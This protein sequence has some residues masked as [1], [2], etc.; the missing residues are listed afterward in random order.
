MSQPIERKHGCTGRTLAN[1]AP[2]APSSMRVIRSACTWTGACRNRA[3]PGPTT[4]YWRCS[5]I[6]TGTEC[7]P[8]SCATQI[9]PAN[10]TTH[11]DPWLP[12]Q[13]IC[14]AMGGPGQ[15]STS[16]TS[17]RLSI[18][19]LGGTNSRRG[20]AQLPNLSGQRSTG[21]ES[22]SHRVAAAVTTSDVVALVQLSC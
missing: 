15:R 7:L 11:D 17:C 4:R 8:M 1:S 19:T 22:R 14:S 9:H 6:T 10:C 20:V 2:G 21:L 3:C 16:K 13:P 18:R 12:P 5:R